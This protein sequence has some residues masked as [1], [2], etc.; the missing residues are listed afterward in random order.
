MKRYLIASAASLLISPLLFGQEPTVQ[1]I[2]EARLDQ[3][4]LLPDAPSTVRDSLEDQAGQKNANSPIR[5]NAGNYG[6]PVAKKYASLIYPGQQALPLSA[7]DKMV[8][9]LPDA[10]GLM[11]LVSIMSS[12]GWSHLIDSSPHYGTNSEAFGKRVGAAALRNVTQSLSTDAV[13]APIFHDDPRYYQMGQGNGFFKRSFYA[14]SRV[15][16][17]R[18]DS[19]HQTLNA[20]LLLGYGTAAGISNLIYPDQDTGAK[21][22]FENYGTSLGGAAVGM[23]A[24]EFLDDALRIVHLRK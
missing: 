21:A 20:P 6:R 13:F 19:G 12:A 1:P 15:V 10:F 11:N 17:T 5:A 22:T 3:P 8:Y 16:V 2:A 9:S 7:T 18:S 14:A 4:A 24:N 23:L